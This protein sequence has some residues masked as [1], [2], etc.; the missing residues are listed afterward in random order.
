MWKRGAGFPES[1]GEV[2]GPCPGRVGVLFVAALRDGQQHDL[3][4][5]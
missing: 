4:S 5:V 1:Q 2:C 3:T